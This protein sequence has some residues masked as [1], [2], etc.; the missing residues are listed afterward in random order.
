MLSWIR[1]TLSASIPLIYF[2]FCSWNQKRVRSLNEDDTVHYWQWHSTLYDYITLNRVHKSV[3]KWLLNFILSKMTFSLKRMMC[4]IY[5]D[6]N[7]SLFSM[8]ALQTGISDLPPPCIW[9]RYGNR[10]TFP[11]PTA[12]DTHASTNCMGLSQLGLA[13]CPMSASC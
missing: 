8:C 4:N 13:S 12:Y 5:H 10:H 7:F 6:L 1:R 9:Q 2:I 11:S 3:E